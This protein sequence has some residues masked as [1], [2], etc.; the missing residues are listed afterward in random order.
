MRRAESL[1][2]AKLK[3]DVG[4]Y[5]IIYALDRYGAANK[6]VLDYLV[7][8]HYYSIKVELTEINR[9]SSLDVNMN[10]YCIGD[11]FDIG[12]R[13]ACKLRGEELLVD[14]CW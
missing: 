2:G 12:L 9:V 3:V 7:Q 11:L 6:K 8:V 13:I 14:Y 5:R 4:I 10:I 1:S